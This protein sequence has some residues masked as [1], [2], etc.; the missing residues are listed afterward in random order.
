VPDAQVEGD[1]V[2]EEEDNNPYTDE[3]FGVNLV[4]RLTKG[5]TDDL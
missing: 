4:F 1:C 2:T 3:F 5:T